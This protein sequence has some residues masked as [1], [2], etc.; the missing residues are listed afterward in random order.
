MIRLAELVDSVALA[1]R[2][3][4]LMSRPYAVYQN[5]SATW[6]APYT[7]GDPAGESLVAI[8]DVFGYCSLVRRDE[9]AR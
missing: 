3:V 8:V 9:E 7:E 2:R 1:A 6:V 4:T 5:T